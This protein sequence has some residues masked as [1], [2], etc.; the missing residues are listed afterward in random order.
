MCWRDQVVSLK[1]RQQPVFDI[2]GLG[3]VL[4]ELGFWK[5]LR[6][7]PGYPPSLQNDRDRQRFGRSKRNA[8]KGETFSENLG[9]L[10]AAIIAY[11]L[12]KG[13][14]P[15][16]LKDEPREPVDDEFLGA[17]KSL[18]VVE[19]LQECARHMVDGVQPSMNERTDLG[20]TMVG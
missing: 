4:I 9:D 11:C 20:M 6:S 15:L 17:Q 10:Y 8:F 2:F 5:R 18:R 1:E 12:E 13:S 7:L 16:A 19:L 3:M 14:D